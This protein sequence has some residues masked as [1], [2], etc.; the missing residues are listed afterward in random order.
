MAET[1]Y[2]NSITKDNSKPYS[3]STPSENNSEDRYNTEYTEI[4]DVHLYLHGSAGY[5][6]DGKHAEAG[7]TAAEVL[8]S[9]ANITTNEDYAV[10]SHKNEDQTYADLNSATNNSCTK[11][12]ILK[13]NTLC[14]QTKKRLVTAVVIT[15]LI[16][17]VVAL[18]VVVG[19]L[20]TS[21]TNGGDGSDGGGGDI[22]VSTGNLS[23]PSLTFR[24]FL[25][26]VSF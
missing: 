20:L 26:A 10:L 18:A 12:D 25:T 24:K 19:I 23:T 15:T 1:E 14:L 3:K 6:V 17:L 7:G 16:A 9:A 8:Q 21:K 5:S 11:S 13:S 22:E 4:G 2:Y